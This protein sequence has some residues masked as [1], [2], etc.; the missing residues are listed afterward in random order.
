MKN[1]YEANS[2]L[3]I[4]LDGSGELKIMEIGEMQFSLQEAIEVLEKY[5][6]E[7]EKE[8]KT[9]NAFSLSDL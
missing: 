2:G 8:R 4:T 3:L 6:S 5:K 9:I 7:I 1:V